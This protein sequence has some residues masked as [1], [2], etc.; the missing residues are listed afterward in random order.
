MLAVQFDKGAMEELYWWIQNH[1]KTALKIVELI[2]IS[3]K[4]PFDGLGKP[5]PLKAN[6][7]GY[8]SRRITG[9]HRLVY[10]VETDSVI[11]VSLKGHY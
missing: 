5:E 4:T 7:K 6:W 10:K 9:E 3:S 2:Q 11:I 8:W 1:H